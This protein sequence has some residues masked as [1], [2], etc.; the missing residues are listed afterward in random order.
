MKRLLSALFFGI[1]CFPSCLKSQ[2][3]PRVVPPSPE[4]A[5]AFKFTEIPVSLYTGL[6]NID[7]PLFVIESGGV[8]VPISLSYHAR[9][10]QVSEIASRVGT[11]W[12]LNAGGAITR[13]VRGVNDDIA[14]QACHYS[15]GIFNSLSRRYSL[16]SHFNTGND[17]LCD[18]IPDQYSFSVNGLSG[19]FIYYIND[20]SSPVDSVLVISQKYSNEKVLGRSL[21]IDGKG[22]EYYFGLNNNKD[23]EITLNKRT[24]QGTGGYTM[25]PSLS[26]EEATPLPN[27]FHL[28]K[29]KSLDSSEINFI[30]EPE[31]TYY[32]RRSGDNGLIPDCTSSVSYISS[33][34][35]RI[36][37]IIFEQGSVH[38][39]YDNVDRLDLPG[40]R[41]LKKIT[42]RNKLNHTI[43]VVEFEYEYTTAPNDGNI[44]EFLIYDSSA[45]KRLFLKKIYIKDN[46]SNSLPP[47]EFEY[48]PTVLPSR[49]S[50][51]SDV[52]GYY[53]GKN[54]GTF[55]ERNLDDR[56]VDVNKVQAGLLTSITKPEGGRILFEYEPNRAVN[57][58]PEMVWFDSPNPIDD[59]NITISHL[60]YNMGRIDDETGSAIF[61]GTNTFEDVFDVSTTVYGNGLY[62]LTM[63]GVENCPCTGS[64]CNIQNPNAMCVYSIQLLKLNTTT[65]TYDNYTAMY[66]NV[67]NRTVTLT[68]GRYKIK[69]QYS[70]SNRPYNPALNGE[71]F[72][73]NLSW[74]EEDYSTVPPEVVYSCMEIDYSGNKVI[75]A[76]GNR[77]KRIE[78]YD[79]DNQLE[80]FKSYSYLKP[81]TNYTSG[82]VLGLTS[83]AQVSYVNWFGQTV[84]AF[85]Q[86][87]SVA[88]MFNTYQSNAVG[89]QYVTE[90]YGDVTNNIGKVEYEYSMVYDTGR[91]Y[92]FPQHPPTDNE[93]LRGKELKIKYFKNNGGNYSLVKEID[94]T[95][96]V[97][98]EAEISSENPNFCATSVLQPST[99][100]PMT[101]NTTPVYITK[102]SNKALFVVP[103]IYLP[104]APDPQY[105]NGGNRYKT[106]YFTGGTIDLKKTKLTEYF[107]V[108]NPLVTE[109]IYTYKYPMHYNVFEESKSTSNGE[110]LLSKFYY[111]NDL[112]LNS[113]PYITEL[114]GKNITDVPL[115]IQN[116]KGTTKLSEQRT[117]Y[118][119]N[120]FGNDTLILPQHIL[121]SKGTNSLENRIEYLQYDDKGNPLD[122]KQTNGT[123]IVY[124]WGYNQSYPIAKIENATYSQVSSYVSNL[125]TLSN[126]TNESGLI[127]ALDTL[128]ANLPN[129]LVTTYIYKPL[130]GVTSITDPRG[131]RTTYHY[132]SFGRLE[133]VK[134][135]SGN[136]LQHTT[137]NYQN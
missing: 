34:Q 106:Y 18:V 124:I 88:G 114:R 130:V 10:I 40:G 125:Q 28:S 98:N 36:S 102:E 129:A 16:G 57:V 86:H 101:Q 54:N 79:S 128:R 48:N 113:E 59:K 45:Y 110:Q 62:S 109:T 15:L 82:K 42:L 22:N 49:H 31:Q 111:S 100:T 21:I 122:V 17:E 20:D 85:D 64:G 55:L 134:D 41:C 104:L 89:Y 68:P 103:N 24:V 38:F 91:Y 126:G 53:N 127:S 93:W 95:Y 72:L 132:D 80:L 33:T 9:G 83:I 19:K 1:I 75:Y 116:Y 84:E 96:L 13:Q 47:Y 76:A 119:K 14:N 50:T 73:F 87:S 118:N 23:F 51:S 8:S 115:M 37:S 67:S 27:T 5:Q 12:T 117:R 120:I 99:Y 69:I 29:I 97:T 71:Y 4:A 46:S 131:Y 77:I 94:N 133:Y 107:D 74:K 52:W 123:H 6:P 11:G 90:Y 39:E 32:Y 2:E 121:T 112:V 25:S 56:R 61:N 58:F 35:Q 3:L 135:Q 136:I 70:G 78:Y 30:Y 26:L 81:G 66:R 65:N 44:N 108:S 137:Y 7:I 63:I 92:E 43:K 60:D 105:P